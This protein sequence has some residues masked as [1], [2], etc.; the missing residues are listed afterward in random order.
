[1]VGSGTISPATCIPACWWECGSFKALIEGI[2]TQSS[3][4]QGN[5]ID[6]SFIN[7]TQGGSMFTCGGG[8]VTNRDGATLACGESKIRDRGIKLKH[9]CIESDDAD[10]CRRQVQGA[11]SRICHSYILILRGSIG[12]ADTKVD[13]IR[14]VG[15]HRCGGQISKLH[16][17]IGIGTPLAVIANLRRGDRVRVCGIVVVNQGACVGHGSGVEVC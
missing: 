11:S 5:I 15:E 3:S 2:F 6:A 1:M 8:D 17:D 4:A 12:K 16:P 14:C 7:H 10:I 13:C 9:G